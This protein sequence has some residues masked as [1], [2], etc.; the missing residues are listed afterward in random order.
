MRMLGSG[1]CSG[2]G[3]DSAS[4]GSVLA[5]K[6]RIGEGSGSGE[7]LN[8]SPPCVREPSSVTM[9]LRLASVPHMRSE[10]TKMPS[11]SKRACVPGFE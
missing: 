3:L 10:S 6:T 11:V 1:R 7:L 2:A 5:C 9:P 8:A 4:E